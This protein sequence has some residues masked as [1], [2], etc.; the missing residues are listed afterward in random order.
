MKEW[1]SL[2]PFELYITTSFFNIKHEIPML[3]EPHSLGPA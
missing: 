1:F 3:G 2:V